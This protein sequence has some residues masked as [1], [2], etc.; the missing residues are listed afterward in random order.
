M[1]SPANKVNYQKEMEREIATVCVDGYRPT[2]LLHACCAP[3]SSAVMER[4]YKYFR[5][6]V[7]FYNPNIAPEA[8]FAHRLE[9]LKRLLPA[10][11]MA[12]VEIVCPPYDGEAFEAI[13]KGREELPEGGAR[14]A[15]CYRLRQEA[16]A[17]YA[18]AHEFEYM[19]TT[20]SVSPHKNAVWLNT[21]GKEL[22]DKYGVRYLLSDFKKQNGY[23]RSCDL[24]VEHG[25]YRQ[26]YCGCIYSAKE[27]SLREAARRDAP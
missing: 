21:I 8:E 23:K 16:T 24:S 15:A 7:F 22:E 9:E 4:L 2:L 19:T 12:D 17:A 20:L 18:G 25:L 10:M 26:N 11:N 3:C 6:T 13:A 1:I 14:C 27:A 5:V